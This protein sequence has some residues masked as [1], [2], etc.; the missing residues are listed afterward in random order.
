MKRRYQAII[1]LT[2]TFGSLV[3]AL[4]GSVP[5]RNATQIDGASYLQSTDG[6]SLGPEIW[7]D[8]LTGQT[9]W[10]IYPDNGTEGHLAFRNNSLNL[11][12]FF[13]ASSQSQAVSIY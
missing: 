10:Q 8:N 12:V 4:R 11:S 6:S 7:A 13:P 3:L 2:L 9:T 1:I 5:E